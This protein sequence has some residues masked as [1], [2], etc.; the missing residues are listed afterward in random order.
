MCERWMCANEC[1]S[2]WIKSF[3]CFLLVMN[4]AENRLTFFPSFLRL[5]KGVGIPLDINLFV[6]ASHGSL[7]THSRINL[8]SW[9][10]LHFLLATVLQVDRRTCENSWKNTDSRLCSFSISVKM[11]AHIFTFCYSRETPTTTLAMPQNQLF[12]LLLLHSCCRWNKS[13]Q[14]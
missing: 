7:C 11:C 8:Y 4:T 3:H 6:L 14:T 5:S 12:L 10:L 1:Y 2:T 13:Q 9:K